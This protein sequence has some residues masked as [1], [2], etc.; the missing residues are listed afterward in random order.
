MVAVFLDVRLHCRLPVHLLLPLLRHEAAD[1]GYGVD[2]SL[3][4]LHADYGV[5]V[6]LADRLDRV[7]CV[8]LV[9]AQDLQRREGGLEEEE[10]DR[11]SLKLTYSP[12]ARVLY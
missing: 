9:R 3:F 5:P 7:L 11:Q 10:E 6:F 4:W 12:S 1:R 8:L 2:V